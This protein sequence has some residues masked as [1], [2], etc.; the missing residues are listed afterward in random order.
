[1]LQAAYYLYIKTALYILVYAQAAYYLYIETAMY[2][3]VY[4]LSCLLPVH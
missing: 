3:L 4:A 2:I 1:M